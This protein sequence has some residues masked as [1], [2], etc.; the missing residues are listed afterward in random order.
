VGEKTANAWGLHDMSG[1]V[2]EWC[3]DQWDNNAYKSRSGTV[4]DPAVYAAGPSP[5]A[6]RGGCW[7]NGADCCRVACRRWLGAGDHKSG[8]GVRLLRW[9]LDS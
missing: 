5:R 8:L 7:V 1:N 4:T 3:A 2:W 6:F 9:N